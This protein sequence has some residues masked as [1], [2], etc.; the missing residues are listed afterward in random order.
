[1]MEIAGFE[2]NDGKSHNPIVSFCSRVGP[3]ATLMQG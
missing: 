1:M 3:F 2:I